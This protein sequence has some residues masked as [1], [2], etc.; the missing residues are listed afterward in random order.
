M[1]WRSYEER[2]FEGKISGENT[3]YFG[4]ELLPKFL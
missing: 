1:L 3:Y 4:S 2:F